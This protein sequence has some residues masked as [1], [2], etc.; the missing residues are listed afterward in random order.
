MRK[1]MRLFLFALLI[2]ALF[3]AVAPLLA[4]AVTPEPPVIATVAPTAAPVIVAAP[5][6]PGLVLSTGDVIAVLLWI[7]LLVVALVVALRRGYTPAQLDTLAA[8]KITG[9]SHDPAMLDRL[10]RAYQQNTEV[11]KHAF[12]TFVAAIK[13]VAPLTPIKTDD[14]IAKLGEEIQA[15][16][17]NPSQPQS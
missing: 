6:A 10:E 3:V 14:A 17:P 4:Q 8:D 15:P 5:S 11:T 7:I 12:D 2:L 1:I 13:L 9:L 16:P